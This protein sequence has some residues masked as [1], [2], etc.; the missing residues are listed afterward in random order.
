MDRR[1]FLSVT[2]SQLIQGQG[3]RIM[4]EGQVCRVESGEFSISVSLLVLRLC[5]LRLNLVW[6]NILF[7]LGVT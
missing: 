5:P 1:K 4:M 2:G 6:L 3:R 7:K